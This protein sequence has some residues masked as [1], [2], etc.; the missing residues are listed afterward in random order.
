[1]YQVYQLHKR[2]SVATKRSCIVMLVKSPVEGSVKSRLLPAFDQTFIRQLYESFVIDLID[3]LKQSGRHFRIAF[4]PADQ[5]KEIARLFGN[6]D[7]IPQVGADLGERMKNIFDRCFSEQYATVVI[8]G[9][10][11]PDLPAR[12]FI[13]ALAVL[14]HR[15]VVIGP[16]ADGGYYLI[17]FR[18]EALIPEVFE[19]IAWSTGTV[20][21]ETM[22]RLNRAGKTVH[23]LPLW[24]DVDTPEDLR[25][26]FKRHRNTPFANS[27]TMAT[28]RSSKHK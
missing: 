23:Q 15:D 14:E 13:E 11:T 10:D 25:D 12:I 1:M 24:R 19:G 9:S 22:I 26:L 18:K 17:G 27:R 2:G 3:T 7:L 28:P 8:I 20:F 5:E 16:A 6:H 4:T 21:P